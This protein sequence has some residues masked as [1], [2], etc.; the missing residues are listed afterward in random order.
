MTKIIASELPHGCIAC[1]FH[2]VFN[3]EN[4]CRLIG[5]TDLDDFEITFCRALDC[6]L[7]SFTEAMQNYFNERE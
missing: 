6:P 5:L 4:C 3:E 7:I 1:Q 2:Y